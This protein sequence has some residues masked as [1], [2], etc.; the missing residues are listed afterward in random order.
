MAYFKAIPTGAA[1]MSRNAS[2]AEK[3]SVAVIRKAE[4]SLLSMAAA[5]RELIQSSWR[6]VLVAPGDFASEFYAA[7]FERAPA[8][9]ALFPGDMREQQQRLTQ[10]MSD[11]IELVATPQ[12]L[13][14]LLRATGVRHLHYRVDPAHFALLGEVL[15]D[16][17]AARDQAFDVATDVAWRE[18]YAA[19]SIIMRGGMQQAA[20]S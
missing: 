8:V 9:A 16:T 19:M 18:F 4:Q 20:Q 1:C 5:Q 6:S 13:V 14:M 7:L 2:K 15:C 12:E 17:I 10:T 3:I 11:A